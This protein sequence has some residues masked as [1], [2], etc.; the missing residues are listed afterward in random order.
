MRSAETI[1]RLVISAAIAVIYLKNALSGTLTKTLAGI[2]VPTNSISFYPLYA[3]LKYR[4]IP[5]EY[6]T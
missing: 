1:I 3:A 5:P 4:H 6:K 2:F